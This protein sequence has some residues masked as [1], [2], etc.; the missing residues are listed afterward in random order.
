[1]SLKLVGISSMILI[2]HYI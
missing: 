2:T 1:M